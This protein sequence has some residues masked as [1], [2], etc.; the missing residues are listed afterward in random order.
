MSDV[1]E[2]IEDMRASVGRYLGA[3]LENQIDQVIR[4]RVN[5]AIAHSL[6]ESLDRAAREVVGAH[7]FAVHLER[8]CEKAIQTLA[9]R[10]LDA[11]LDKHV[12]ALCNMSMTEQRA[13]Q[14]LDIAL[15][16]YVRELVQGL[17]NDTEL[18]QGLARDLVRSE[19]KK[20]RTLET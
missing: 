3:T 11:A 14:A 8:A 1:D 5:E 10:K 13:N 20:R 2:A 18:M 12:K 7:S 4:E 17:K 19:L 15:R 9:G 16:T 6:A